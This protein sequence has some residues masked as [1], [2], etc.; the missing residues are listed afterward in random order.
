MTENQFLY[1]IYIYLLSALSFFK[2]TLDLAEDEFS[3]DESMDFLASASSVSKPRKRST[4]SAGN[5]KRKLMGTAAATLTTMDHQDGG[6]F[7]S[8]IGRSAEP[9][10]EPLHF[11]KNLFEEGKRS[12]C[13]K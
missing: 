4:S 9:E 13:C 2:T 1:Y 12:Q 8:V 6:V 5:E 3:E 11:D 7:G 10:K